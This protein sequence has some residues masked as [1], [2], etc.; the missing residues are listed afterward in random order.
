MTSMFDSGSFRRLAL[1]GIVAAVLAALACQGASSGGGDTKLRIGLSFPEA[2]GGTPLDGRHAADGLDRRTARSRGSRSATTTR[3]SRSSASTSTG[4]KPGP[5][6]GDR[7]HRA[8]LSDGQPAKASR[9]ATTGCRGCCTSTRPSSA[10]TATCE[11]AD[12]SRRRPAVGRRRRGISTARRKIRL[13][14][15]SGDDRPHRRWTRR[16]RRMPTGRTRSTSSTSGSRASGSRSSGAARCTSARIV[17]LPEGFDAHPNAHYPL[18]IYHG[19]FQ[20]DAS[21]RGARR[22]PI[23]RCR[24]RRRGLAQYCRTGMRA[25]R[26]RSSATSAA[27]GVRLQASTRNGPAPRFPAHDHARRSSTPTRTTTTRTP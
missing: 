1:G 21:A 22:R 2:Q 14:P 17:V 12:G 13:D 27:P 20:R 8:R 23:R 6:G 25:T 19:H 24:G 18:A 10:P 16:F 15:A 4:C 11:A 7:Q 3:P 5:G 26:A 9:P